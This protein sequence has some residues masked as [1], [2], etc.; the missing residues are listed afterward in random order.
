MKRPWPKGIGLLISVLSL[1]SLSAPVT[2]LVWQDVANELMSPACPGRTLINC[3]SG[4]SDQWRELIRQKLAKGET[5]EQII[6]HFVKM[7][8]EEILAAPPKKGFALAAWLLPLFF[9]VNGAG[10]IV[11]LTYRWTRK[12]PAADVDTAISPNALQQDQTTS[13]VYRDR[14]R[15]DLEEFNS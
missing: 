2:A 13:D 4:Q 9:V 6:Q 7:S 10:L 1:L 3:T 11:A 5:K 12:R 14:L 8:G 15:S